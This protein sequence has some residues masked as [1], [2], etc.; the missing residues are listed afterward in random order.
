MGLHTDPVIERVRTE[1]LQGADIA[2]G[3]HV[4]G[5]LPAGQRLV[6][7]PA[8][9]MFDCRCRIGCDYCEPLAEGPT[10]RVSLWSA[11]TGSTVVG[12]MTA[13]APSC[14]ASAAPF[15]G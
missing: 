5:D 12:S 10:P 4:N 3:G 9:G 6:E 13:L 14:L 11:A 7:Q 15:C 8:A 2:V 1:D